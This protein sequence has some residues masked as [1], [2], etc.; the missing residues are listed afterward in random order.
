MFAK[1]SPKTS[2]MTRGTDVQSAG[3]NKAAMRTPPVT[4]GNPTPR[5]AATRWAG[6]KT[7]SPVPGFVGY[8]VSIHPIGC[9]G[10]NV[11]FPT[12]FLGGAV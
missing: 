12:Q 9:N 2:S 1:F 8:R 7:R 10:K 5:E 3:E 11:S 4:T 6:R